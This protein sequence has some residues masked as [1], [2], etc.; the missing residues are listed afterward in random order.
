MCLIKVFVVFHKN[1][2]PDIYQISQEDKL[3]YVTFY[4]VNYQ[5]VSKLN[6]I[7]EYG[8]QFYNPRWQTLNYNEASAFYHI[9]IKYI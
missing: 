9:Y 5:Q 1:F 6:I 4:G 2:Y 7:Y 3:K 8:F